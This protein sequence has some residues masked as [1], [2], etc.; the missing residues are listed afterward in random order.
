MFVCVCVC[1]HAN[2]HRQTDVRA[3]THYWIH[4]HIHTEA[5]ESA[6]CMCVCVRTFKHHIQSQMSSYQPMTNLHLCVGSVLLYMWELALIPQPLHYHPPP[7]A[8]PGWLTDG[9]VS[10]DKKHQWLITKAHLSAWGGPGV[11]RTAGP[12]RVHLSWAWPPD[13]LGQIPQHSDLC[14]HHCYT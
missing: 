5:D 8:L 10:P 1:V 14:G 11:P 13:S 3:F 7:E 6:L 2:L 12:K 4:T 9:R